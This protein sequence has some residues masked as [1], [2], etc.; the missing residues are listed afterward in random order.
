MRLAVGVLTLGL[1]GCFDEPPDRKNVI[2]QESLEPGVFYQPFLNSKQ[3]ASTVDTTVAYTG[4]ASLRY[5]VPTP[6]EPNAGAFNYSGGAYTSDLP[7]DL[8]GFNALTFWAK[9]SR[10]VTLN[11]LGIANDNTGTSRYQ[12]EVA[13]LPFTTAWTRYV[14]P[15]PAPRKLTAERGLLWLASDAKGTPPTGYKVWFDDVKYD[16]VDASGWNPRPVLTGGARTLGVAETFQV[17]GT[18]VTYALGGGDLTMSVFPATFEWQS[19]NPAV[20]RVSDAGLVTG[21]G[22][23]AAVISATLGEL[24]VSQ[25]YTVNVGAGLA[26]L[27]GPAVPTP[28]QADVISLYSDH[29]TAHPVDKLA[30]DWSN[31][32]TGAPCTRWS[33]LSLGGDHVMRYGELAF[34]AI[35]ALGP[36]LVDATAMTHV[37]VDFWT[38]DSTY[39]KLKLVDFGANAVFGGG[40]DKEHELTFNA[41]SSPALVTGQWVSL[42]IPLASFTGLTTRAH[43]AQV[44]FSASNATVFVD[45]VYFHR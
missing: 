9:A 33:E 2:F 21:V 31:G 45:N 1:S 27:A 36:N 22:P 13:A 35:E 30:A 16:A 18:A 11:S 37:H 19:S 23:G 24:P 42:D 28:L 39:F 26:P 41:S 15:V 3:D 7:R 17:G 44:V 20:A 12:T 34:T 4:S 5:A 25:T 38:H 29:Y 10:T 43:L 32:C 14:I 8:S 6:G 40:D